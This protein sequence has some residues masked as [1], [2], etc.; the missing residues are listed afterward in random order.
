MHRSGERSWLWHS[1]LRS[2]RR[3]RRL[4]RNRFQI[5]NQLH[6]FFFAQLPRVARH[7]VIIS[8]SDLFAGKQ[9]C[10]AEVLLVRFD[11]LAVGQRNGFVEKPLEQG[12][13]KSRIQSVTTATTAIEKEPATSHND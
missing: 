12:R 5:G 10:V 6:D 9:N 2:W 3:W 4:V 8:G 1:K 11:D 13:V 7:D